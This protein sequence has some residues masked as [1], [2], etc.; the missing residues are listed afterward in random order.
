MAVKF[1]H[2]SHLDVFELPPLQIQFEDCFDMHGGGKRAFEPHA[3]RSNSSILLSVLFG[4]SVNS[5][6]ISARANEPVVPSTETNTLQSQNA[7]RHVL[8]MSE[9]S[10]LFALDTQVS[11]S[12][13]SQMCMK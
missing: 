10:F 3:L 1:M 5:S 12:K 8:R 9:T 7:S 4:L 13:K 6:W 11:T 2:L